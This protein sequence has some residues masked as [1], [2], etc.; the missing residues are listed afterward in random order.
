LGAL[1]TGSALDLIG[2]SWTY[3]LLSLLGGFGLLLTMIRWP[4]LQQKRA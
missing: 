1:I 4:E 3:F 2:Y